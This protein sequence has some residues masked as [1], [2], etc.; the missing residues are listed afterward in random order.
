MR[1]YALELG[2][3]VRRPSLDEEGV[4]ERAY[5]ELTTFP[6]PRHSVPLGEKKVGELNEVK[7]GKREE[8]EFFVLFLIILF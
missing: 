6:A 4:A 8:R 3:S 2:K 1:I 7:P 5:D